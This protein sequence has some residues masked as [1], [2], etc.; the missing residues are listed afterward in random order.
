MH[1]PRLFSR[2]PNHRSVNSDKITGADL[3]GLVGG[4]GNHLHIRLS[5]GGENRAGL[6]QIALPH[7]PPFELDVLRM[8]LVAA[9]GAGGS[10]E[11]GF[12]L[13]SA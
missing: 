2:R 13:T 10:F 8:A 3:L 11:G 4:S 1:R 9:Q 12:Q 5:D 6:I 7:R